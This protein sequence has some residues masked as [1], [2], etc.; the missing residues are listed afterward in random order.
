MKRGRDFQGF[1]ANLAVRVYKMRRAGEKKRELFQ[2]VQD[3]AYKW[4]KPRFDAATKTILDM[5]SEGKKADNVTDADYTPPAKKKP[6]TPA[7]AQAPVP[8]PG[9]DHQPTAHKL[10][11]DK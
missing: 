9:S 2:L 5:M 1:L 10:D 3:A 6:D 8:P 4:G 7:A 11:Y